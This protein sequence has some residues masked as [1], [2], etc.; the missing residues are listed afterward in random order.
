MLL[1]ILLPPEKSDNIFKE[2]GF[3]GL[4]G[5]YISPLASNFLCPE[6]CG[7]Q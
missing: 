6:S 7:W 1:D 4:Q 2:Y 5:P 3:G